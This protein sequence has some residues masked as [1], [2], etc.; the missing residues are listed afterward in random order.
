MGRSAP[1]AAPAREEQPMRDHLEE[2]ASRNAVVTGAGSG[3][4]RALAIRLAS[5]G[6]SVGIGDVDA[7]G[8][9][10]TSRMVRQAGGAVAV[11]V[12]DVRDSEEFESAVRTLAG[13][14]GPVALLINNAGIAVAGLTGD[15]DP[16]DWRRALEINVMGC[17]NGCHVAVPMM[18]ENGGGHIVNVASA[19]GYVCLPEMGPYNV[20]KAAVIAL[21]ETLRSEVSPYGIGVTVACPT[22]FNTGLAGAMVYTDEWQKGFTDSAFTNARMQTD[23]VARRILAAASRNRLYALPQFA[24]RWTRVT[25][26]LSPSLHHA[27]LGLVCRSGSARRAADALARR[28]LV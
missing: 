13:E 28:G 14:L 25:K 5:D 27:A 8:A 3:L 4:G 12:F 7:A 22:F 1:S 15:V 9:Q 6:W 19:A 21:S 17:V 24:A 23:E 10:E 2:L 18:K 26:R 11:S 20:S 16:A